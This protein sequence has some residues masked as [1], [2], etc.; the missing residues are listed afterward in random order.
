MCFGILLKLRQLRIMQLPQ[1]FKG[2]YATG[3]F[4]KCVNQP[5][6]AL[7]CQCCSLHRY[8]LKNPLHHL[9][10][11]QE[12]IVKL[13]CYSRSH[14][15]PTCTRGSHNP[16]RSLKKWCK[17]PKS[18]GLPQTSAVV[19]CQNAVVEV[20]FPL[21]IHLWKLCSR[22]CLTCFC[23]WQTPLV[24]PLGWSFLAILGAYF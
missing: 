4:C 14:L 16:A 8:I 7:P 20:P 5:L 24:A 21:K 19:Q 12:L 2:I 6:A 10:R 15:E 11:N 22:C 3:G 17:I 18:S 13:M 1:V 23:F 9:L